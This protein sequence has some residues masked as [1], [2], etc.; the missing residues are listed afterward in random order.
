MI[1]GI[2]SAPLLAAE[3]GMTAVATPPSVS[4]TSSTRTGVAT[5]VVTPSTT[6]T[7]TGGTSPYTHSWATTNPDATATAPPAATTA[8]EATVDP[9]GSV[10]ATFI[11]T[12]TDNNGVVTTAECD[13]SMHLV[14]LS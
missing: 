11:D 4:K 5:L 9:G 8:F 3:Q 7:V 14:D 2:V 1:P 13:A 10:V 12:V 6:V